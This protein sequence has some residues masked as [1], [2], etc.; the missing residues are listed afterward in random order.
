MMAPVFIYYGKVIGAPDYTEE[1]L[2]E[3]DR[4]L[5]TEERGHLDAALADRGMEFRRVWKWNG[6][7]PD[8]TGTVNV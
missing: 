5:T 1:I 6:E 2:L 4:E 3:L 7:A 8:F